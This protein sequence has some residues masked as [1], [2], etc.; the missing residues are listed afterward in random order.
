MVV[1]RDL[2]VIENVM[3][4]EQVVQGHEDG[5]IDETLL[6]EEGLHGLVLEILMVMIIELHLVEITLSVEELVDVLSNLHLRE[7]MLQIEFGELKRLV[8]DDR[9][10]LLLVEG[11]LNDLVP[12]LLIRVV[13][14]HQVVDQVAQ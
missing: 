11:V 7:V 10:D 1:D 6:V 14:E 12:H 2:L 8:V 5:G 13:R 3:Q 4:V 9:H